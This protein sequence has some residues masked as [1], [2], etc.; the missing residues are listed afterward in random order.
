MKRLFV[1][2]LTFMRIGIHPLSVT[3]AEDYASAVFESMKSKPSIWEA[4][5]AAG[6]SKAYHEREH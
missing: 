4:S 3:A 5:S 6:T 2:I 1:L